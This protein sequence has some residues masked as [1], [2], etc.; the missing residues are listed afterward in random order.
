[1]SRTKVAYSVSRYAL[2]WV[3]PG[4]KS[5]RA[6]NVTSLSLVPRAEI[7]QSEAKLPV[8]NDAP[9]CE[10]RGSS[11]SNCF[12]LLHL[13]SGLH[14]ALPDVWPQLRRIIVCESGDLIKRSA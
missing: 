11:S 12:N 8:Q 14:H 13:Q 2:S 6:D 9:I 3:S 1:M 7:S 4:G 10:V 5:R